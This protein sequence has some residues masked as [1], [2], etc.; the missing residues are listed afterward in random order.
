MARVVSNR[1]R[2][3]ATIERHVPARR[4][5]VY[6]DYLQ[7]GHRRL[8]VAPLSVRPLRR[9]P[10]STPLAWDELRPDLDTHDFNIAT[11][12]ARLE[13][14]AGDPMRAVLDFVPDLPAVLE[15]LLAHLERSER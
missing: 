9:A 1:L 2:D 7:N 3:I 10:V 14:S 13:A 4:G 8:L 12:P 15:R 5:R 6:I 11:V